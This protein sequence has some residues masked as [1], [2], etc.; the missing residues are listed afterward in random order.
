MRLA[1]LVER[2]GEVGD[3]RALGAAGALDRIEHRDRGVEV[4]EPRVDEGERDDLLAEDLADLAV[5]VAGGA[6]AGAGEDRV[7]DEQEVALAL[8]DLDADRRRRSRCRGTSP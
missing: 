7:A 8:V 4:V 2:G 3:V 1:R 6:E 5:A